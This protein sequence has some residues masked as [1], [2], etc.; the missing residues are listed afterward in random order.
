M[1]THV[2]PAQCVI[3]YTPHSVSE[4]THP[5]CV[6]PRTCTLV[7]ARMHMHPRCVPPVHPRARVVYSRS[8]TPTYSLYVH[9]PPTDVRR[10]HTR[11]CCCDCAPLARMRDA[12]PTHVHRDVT[13]AAHRRA[14]LAA[15]FVWMSHRCSPWAEMSRCLPSLG[16][17]CA[18]MT[19]GLFDGDCLPAASVGCDGCRQLVARRFRTV[20]WLCVHY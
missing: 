14:S 13:N 9:P 6:H 12:R 20:P 18:Q 1:F 4:S 10:S 2:T 8:D 11:M 5:L 16:R 3:T 7:H 19:G 15:R 17:R